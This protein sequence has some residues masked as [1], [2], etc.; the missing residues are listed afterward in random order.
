MHGMEKKLAHLFTAVG[1]LFFIA[2]IA[3]FS[4]RV[5][6]LRERNVAYYEQAFSAFR[7]RLN[8]SYRLGNGFD[9][10]E[11]RNTAREFLEEIP[12]LNT[13]LVFSYDTGLLYFLPRNSEQL[14]RWSLDFRGSALPVRRGLLVLEARIR[15]SLL[16][17]GMNGVMMEGIFTVLP[18]EELF[19]VIRDTFILAAAFFLLTCIM[20][21]AMRLLSDRGQV[22][23]PESRTESFPEEPI[24]SGETPY[25]GGTTGAEAYHT[26]QKPEF[27]AGEKDSGFGR[28]SPT[29][30]ATP[31]LTEPRS[32]SG[33]E[34]DILFRENIPEFRPSAEPEVFSIDTADLEPGSVTIDELDR[35]EAESSREPV[36]QLEEEPPESWNRHPGSEPQDEIRQTEARVRESTEMRPDL[37]TN[38]ALKDTEWSPAV[39]AVESSLSRAGALE[40]VIGCV[41]AASDE[42]GDYGTRRLLGI[43]E[44]SLPEDAEIVPY[45]G[46]SYLFSVTGTTLD[47]M[48][49]EAEK[50]NRLFHDDTGRFLRIGLSV[51]SGRKVTAERLLT[52][53]ERALERTRDLPGERIVGFRPDPKKYASLTREDR[54]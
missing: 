5:Y 7:D 37:P 3:L 26:P 33:F 30:I 41:E 23:K 45:R 46:S 50:M 36:P 27:G 2:V 29:G 16:I 38:T 14:E 15:T 17:P 49:G 22:P 32:G 51:R 20:I 47:E 12:A 25:T 39:R 6:T 10:P 54:R 8:A 19:P 9:S 44:T 40:V 28:V 4:Y 1:I 42:T 48:I 18:D 34:S 21:A 13:F 11:F 35:L 31:G 52:E 24:S 53:I 43:L